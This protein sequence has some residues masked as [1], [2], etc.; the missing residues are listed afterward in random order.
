MSFQQLNHIMMYPV[1][2]PS[3]KTIATRLKGLVGS[4]SDGCFFGS[5]SKE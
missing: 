5:S 1:K 2:V 4:S 3:T